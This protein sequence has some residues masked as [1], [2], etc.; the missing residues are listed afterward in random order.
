MK[1]RALMLLFAAFT[2]TGCGQSEAQEDYE[3]CNEEYASGMECTEEE[4]RDFL[5]EDYE[6]SADLI[7]GAEEATADTQSK[8]IQEIDEKVAEI[9]E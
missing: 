1:K 5:I 3:T 4:F 2:L 8:A 9:F 6:N 7:G